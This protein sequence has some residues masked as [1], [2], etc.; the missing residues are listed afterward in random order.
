MPN[1]QTSK[2]DQPKRKRY[3]QEGRRQTNRIRKLSRH[4]KKYGEDK[5]AIQA[6]EKAKMG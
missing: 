2:R 3:N 4:L 5:Q 6:L 1:K